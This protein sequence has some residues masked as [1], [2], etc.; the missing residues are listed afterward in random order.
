MGITLYIYEAYLRRCSILGRKLR[1]AVVLVDVFRWILMREIVAE[2]A[3]FQRGRI[4]DIRLF[5]LHDHD[6]P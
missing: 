5:D 2:T 1:T 6:H 4:P 3:G